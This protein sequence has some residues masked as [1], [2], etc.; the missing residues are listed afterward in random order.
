LEETMTL[1]EQV[2]DGT[3]PSPPEVAAA[4]RPP[5]AAAPAGLAPELPLVGGA[6]ELAVLVD[7]HARA[8]PDGGLAVIEGEAGIGKTRLAEEL[9]GDARGR[10]AGGRAARLPDREGGRPRL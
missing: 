10:G 8:Q 6:E 5:P 7:A 1:Y 3:L 2:N 4:L 9:M